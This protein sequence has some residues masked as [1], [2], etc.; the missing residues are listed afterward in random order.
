MSQTL[1]LAGGN[2]TTTKA[3][4]AAGTTTTFSTANTVQSS[5]AGRAYAKT[6]V[7]NGATPTA[8]GT[9]GAL[10]S[11]RPVLPNQGS[12]FLFGFNAAGAVVVAQGDTKAL[13]AS[14]NFGDAP[15]FPAFPDAAAAFGYLVLKVGATGSAWTLGSSNLS[16][17]TGVMYTFVDVLTL[18]ARPQVA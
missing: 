13:D 8:D 1:D 17:A 5:I 18:P 6:A 11:L 10:F 15:Q 12:V 9:S 14:G 7:T 3:G 2:Y 4:L 16:G